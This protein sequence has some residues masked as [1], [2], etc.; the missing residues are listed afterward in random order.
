[1][2]LVGARKSTR[3]SRS[4]A[5]VDLLDQLGLLVLGF[6]DILRHLVSKIV[7]DFDYLKLCFTDL[8]LCLRDGRHHLATLA[9]KTRGLALQRRLACEGY[10]TLLV[11]TLHT[12]EFAGDQLMLR[13]FRF[14]LGVETRNLF[15][16]LPNMTAQEIFGC[17]TRRGAAVE[18]RNLRCP[19]AADIVITRA[20]GHLVRQLRLVEPIAFRHQA[21]EPHARLV[22]L[23]RQDLCIGSQLRLVEAQEQIARTHMRS[24]T[25]RNA[26]HNATGGMLNLLEVRLHHQ[27]AWHDDRARQRHE[28]CPAPDNAH[29]DD[30]HPKTDF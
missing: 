23:L 24:V 1:M 21:R 19:K 3:L 11:K 15:T 29:A 26:R 30:Q 4:C 28:A 16:E 7:I 8:R 2:P 9:I 18:Q 27:R 13:R 5:A 14:D 12:L 20:A 17:A 22:E 6:A 25:N 10:E